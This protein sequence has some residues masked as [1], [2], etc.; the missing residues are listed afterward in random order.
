MTFSA[1][2]LMGRDVGDI[3]RRI[4]H[5]RSGN[6]LP[7]YPTALGLESAGIGKRRIGVNTGGHK[8]GKARARRETAYQVWRPDNTLIPPSDTFTTCYC[9][10]I[11]LLGRVGRRIR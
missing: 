7:Q 9:C 6:Q 2:N 5:V 3:R 1:A 10:H 11:Q 4:W 8:V